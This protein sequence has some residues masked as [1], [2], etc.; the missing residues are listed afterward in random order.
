V[1][2]PGVSITQRVRE[3]RVFVINVHCNNSPKLSLEAATTTSVT[4]T[5]PTTSSTTPPGPNPTTPSPPP[6]ALRSYAGAIAGGV[7]GG[8]ALIAIIAGV[9]AFF[10]IRNRNRQQ[11]QPY[12]TAPPAGPP[13]QTNMPT[14]ITTEAVYSEKIAPQGPPPQAYYQPGVPQQTYPS[15]EQNYAQTFN[16]TVPPYAPPGQRTLSQVV[17]NVAEL[18]SASSP[19]PPHPS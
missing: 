8:L 10:I 15:H 18:E 16:P 13:S 3:V 6:S 9:A 12:A 17:P 4:T 19:R 14:A 7:V 11:M 1:E 2:K 5:S